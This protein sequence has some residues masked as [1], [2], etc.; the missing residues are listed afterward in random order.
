M[1]LGRRKRHLATHDVTVR[2]SKAIRSYQVA[3]DRLKSDNARSTRWKDRKACGSVIG[4]MRLEYNLNTVSAWR[5]GENNR[6]SAP[7][8]VSPEKRQSI[9]LERAR[10]GA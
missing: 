10:P 1:N 4:R 5:R 3:P 7:L 8:S 6:V 2:V 9:E